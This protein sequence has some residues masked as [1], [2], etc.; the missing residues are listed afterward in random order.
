MK[1]K[2]GSFDELSFKIALNISYNH[3]YE[4]VFYRDFVH[5]KFNNNLVL[6]ALAIFVC[7]LI[8][9]YTLPDYL[10]E[11]IKEYFL[12]SINDQKEK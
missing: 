8:K 2:E 11:Y 12:L 4:T 3:I 10:L 6:A 9:E 5:E 1:E 7:A